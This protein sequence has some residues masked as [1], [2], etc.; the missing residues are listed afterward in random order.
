MVTIS[1]CLLV[2]VTV[3]TLFFALQIA[4]MQK[5]NAELFGL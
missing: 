1:Q 5:K 4:T 3:Q 2:S